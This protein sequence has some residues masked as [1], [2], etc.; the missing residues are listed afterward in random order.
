[1][2]NNEAYVSLKCDLGPVNPPAD[3]PPDLKKNLAFGLKTQIW[4]K[5]SENT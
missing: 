1:M 4:S 2:P 5:L 3:L